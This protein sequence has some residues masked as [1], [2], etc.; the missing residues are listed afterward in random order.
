MPYRRKYGRRAPYRKRRVLPLS[1]LHASMPIGRS[2][3]FIPDI[4]MVRMRAVIPLGSPQNLLGAP[5]VYSWSANDIFNIAGGTSQPYGFDQLCL[6]YDSW[7]VQGSKLTIQIAPIDVT[8]SSDVPVMCGAYVD[9]QAPP[10]T[11]GYTNW[12]GPVEARRGQW[13]GPI[14][15]AQDHLKTLQAYYSPQKYYGAAYEEIAQLLGTGGATPASPG[16]RDSFVMW[17]QPQ[18]TATGVSA[19][20]FRLNIILDYLV[21]WFS[22]RPVPVS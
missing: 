9:S 18:D 10:A 15:G 4:R 14:N 16:Q 3:P 11:F 13:M 6:F 8:V 12:L 19:G 21:Y 7:I 22:P 5:A 20:Y 1:S 17:W 2:V